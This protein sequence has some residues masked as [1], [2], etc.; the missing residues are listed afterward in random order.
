MAE[1]RKAYAGLVLITTLWGISFPVMDMCLTRMGP[2]T[3]VALRYLG[4]AAVM[5]LIYMRARRKIP[6]GA[7]MSGELRSGVMIGIPFAAAAVLQM[8]GLS[9]TSV[10]NA[11]FITGLQV[12]FVPL[13]IWMLERQ[14]PSVRT[15]TGIFL[16]LAG[17]S[18]MTQVWNVNINAGD[19][20][21]LAA[22][23][24]FSLQVCHLEKYG[25]GREPVKLTCVVLWTMA[26]LMLPA[27]AGV[28]KMQIQMDW[29]LM[30]A[31]IFVSFICTA[32]AIF[33]QNLLQPKVPAS[34]AAV[35][36]L[37]EPVTAA[38][39]SFILGEGIMAAQ[40]AGGAI[41]LAGAWII[42]RDKKQG[43]K[44]MGDKNYE[45]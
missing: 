45:I 43:V 41:I 29:V 15:F 25:K 31:L 24:A 11:A 12:V 33:I 4:A 22:A 37:L 44:H 14:L 19:L 6:D 3:F 32:G 16:S 27:A 8:I 38:A 2:F 17:V 23:A 26:L 20:W 42:V 5:S 18:V 9:Q 1:T 10:T 30:S 35:I 28:E 13:L 34:N 7:G 36:Y 39:L 21:V 40:I